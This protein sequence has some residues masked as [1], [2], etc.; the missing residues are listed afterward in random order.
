MFDEETDIHAKGSNEDKLKQFRILA[1]EANSVREKDKILVKGLFRNFYNKKLNVGIG[2]QRAYGAILP[3]DYFDLI[4]LPDGNYLFIFADI[5]GHGLPAY[6]TLIRLRSAV[7]I[8]IKEIKRIYDKTSTLDTH[9]LVKDLSTKFTDIMDDSNSHDF[10]SV[11][12]TFIK[13]DGDMFHLRFYNRGML[14][15]IIMRKFKGELKD[16]YN[17]NDEEKGWEPLKGHLLGSDVRK[18]LKDK[19]LETPHCDF[20]LYEGDS[21]LFFSDGITEAYNKSD[22]LNDFSEKR[23][24]QFLMEN[25]NLAPQVIIH[26]LFN[27]VYEFIGCPEQQKDDMTAVLIDF[28]GVRS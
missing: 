16:I 8:S 15:P 4:K 25:Y 9:F 2:F 6:T 11:N 7:T 5:S 13:N 22:P 10:A 28:P 18:L 20:T 24:E 27:L 23:L 12:F 3:G 17:L 19:Y 26:E 1:A 21:I 14:F